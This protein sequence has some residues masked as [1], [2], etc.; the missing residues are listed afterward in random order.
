MRRGAR[1]PIEELAPF[2]FEAK[3]PRRQRETPAEPGTILDWSSL[4]A[5]HN[6]VEIEVGFGKGL[7]L[8]N[9]GQARPERNFFG[10]EIER[11]YALM[12]ATRLAK[13]GL[14]NVKVTCCDARWFLKAHVGAGAVAAVHV[15]FPDPWW[16]YRHRKRRLFTE[17]FAC[18]CV[19]VLAGGGHLHL[20]TDV[21]DYFAETLQIL[22]RFE[23]L[24]PVPPP[25]AAAPT[26]DMD[27]LTNFER[28][29]RREQRAVYRA[30]WEK[31]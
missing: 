12:T 24:T 29:Y 5:N 28:K 9:A 27:Y 15:Y 8:L 11:K 14:A 4:F 2:L 17:E 22:R 23:P 7:F 6:P 26:H 31:K 20:A 19:R 18:Q 16:K 30:M 1:L 25:E 10:I 13:R 3:A 21:R